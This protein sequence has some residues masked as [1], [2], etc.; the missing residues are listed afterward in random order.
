M[1]LLPLLFACC[2]CCCCFAAVTD[3]GGSYGGIA[4][5]NVAFKYVSDPWLRGGAG[6]REVWACVVWGGERIAS[7][8]VMLQWQVSWHVARGG[9]A[10]STGCKGKGVIRKWRMTGLQGIWGCCAGGV[11]VRTL[12]MQGGSAPVGPIAW[13]GWQT[14][15]ASSCIKD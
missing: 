1:L 15:P 8:N 14:L 7:V 12:Q 2:C 13:H 4:Y 9:R 10:Q 11:C 5:L 3:F 6:V